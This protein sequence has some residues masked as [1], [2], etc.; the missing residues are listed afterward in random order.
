MWA[1][2]GYGADDVAAFERGNWLRWWRGVWAGG[3]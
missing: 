3:G 2:R 1:E